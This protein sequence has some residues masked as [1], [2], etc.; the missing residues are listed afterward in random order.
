MFEKEERMLNEMQK[1]T[2][3]STAVVSDEALDAAVQS[4]MQR[5]RHRQRSRARVTVLS[6][7]VATIAAALLFVVW[8]GS[9]G[10]VKPNEQVAAQGP[11]PELTGFDF[12]EDITLNT[13][14]KYGLI[15]PVNQSVTEGDYTVTVNGILTG[16]QQME[17]FYTIENHA[18]EPADLK[19]IE[20]KRKGS[21]ELLP[22]S[23]GSSGKA[24]KPGETIHSRWNVQ[25]SDNQPIPEELTLSFSITPYSTNTA[26]QSRAENEQVL[27]VGLSVDMETVRKYTTTVSINKMLQ[28]EKQRFY[29]KE[30][31]MSPAGIVLKAN[32]PSSNT[33]KVSG[34]WDVYLESVVSGERIR[35]NSD[36]AFLP[37][38]GGGD[39]TY[40][41]DSNILENP[42]SITLKASGFQ[43]VDPSDMKLVVDTDKKE[44]LRS[45]DGDI[46]F[47]AY[48]GHT[49][50][51]E[52]EEQ[53]DRHMGSVSIEPEFVD[54]EGK[55]HTINEDAGGLSS[56]SRSSSDTEVGLIT[57]Y[58]HLKPEDYP[59]P[60]TFTLSS[61]PGVM[62]QAF[63]VP[64]Q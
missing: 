56:S 48:T 51:L 61:Y 22:Y 7:V 59:Q 18:E 44:V 9:E 3:V 34:L 54:G 63:E 12:G 42:E 37:G 40:F 55:K 64:I 33:M 57:Q 10:L 39:M 6:G 36:S 47:G 14:N 43:A 11:Y 21:S 2:E 29:L 38:A 45:P 50:T 16:S 46:R 19:R 24:I 17:I 26:Y 20:V 25:V 1:D 35:L 27:D 58:I 52:Y 28:I 53:A 62:E 15:Q 31:V 8:S 4:G 23:I 41:F 5:G 49:L 60:L 13:A 30:A 32:I